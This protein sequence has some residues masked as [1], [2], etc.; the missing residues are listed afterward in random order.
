M[1]MIA[2]LNFDLWNLR[3]S[4]L[5][6]SGYHDV[7]YVRTPA[8]LITKTKREY[9]QSLAAFDLAKTKAEQLP[10]QSPG[11]CLHIYLFLPISRFTI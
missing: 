3:T 7:F 6:I 8:T 2:K 4:S 1:A 9:E 10:K 11:E 5:A